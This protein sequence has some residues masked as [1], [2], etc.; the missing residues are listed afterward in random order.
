MLWLHSRFFYFLS[1][2]VLEVIISTFARDNRGNGVATF[3]VSNMTARHRIHQVIVDLVLELFMWR[4][5]VI[6]FQS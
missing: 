3:L 5:Q 1:Q 2:H 4:L 6:G